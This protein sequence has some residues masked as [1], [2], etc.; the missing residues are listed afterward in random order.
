MKNLSLGHSSEL[1]AIQLKIDSLRKN[2]KGALKIPLEIKQKV[3]SLLRQ[4]IPI[5]T[6]SNQCHLSYSTIYQWHHGRPKSSRPSSRCPKESDL[7]KN[8]K[9]LTVLNPSISKMSMIQ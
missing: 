5:N 3:L 2:H 9:V 6:I 8:V 7:A 1:K 4:G